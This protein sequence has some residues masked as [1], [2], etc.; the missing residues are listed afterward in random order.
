MSEIISTD[1]RVSKPFDIKPGR[2]ITIRALGLQD[3]DQVIVEVLSLTRAGPGGNWCCYTGPA[4]AE[5]FDAVPLRCRNG[6]RVI[7]TK[8]FPWATLDAPQQVPLR[9]RVIADDLAQISV[10]MEETESVG[11]DIC[12]CVEPYSAS[13]PLPNGGFGYMDGDFKDCE[14]T[15]A[16]NPCN[17]DG[18][19]VWI[20]PTPRPNATAPVYDC[21]GN[22]VGY[23][24]NQSQSAIQVVPTIPCAV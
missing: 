14:A 1:L 6:A 9:A 4:Q 20:Y 17:G 21:D 18:P 8:A 3:C 15:V 12:A 24:P 23:A 16:V 10:E 13:Y 7:L 2:Q 22:V 19:E 11:C 5:I